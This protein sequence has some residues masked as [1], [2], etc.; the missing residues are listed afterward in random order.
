MKLH[1]ARQVTPVPVFSLRQAC[2]VFSRSAPASGRQRLEVILGCRLCKVT[3]KADNSRLG[4]E[5]SRLGTESSRLGTGSS[6]FGTGSSRLGTECS[7]ARVRLAGVGLGKEKASW[8]SR[9]EGEAGR[10]GVGP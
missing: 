9:G 7:R 3:N 1:S 5:S 2:S 6:R 4:T 8:L 10:L